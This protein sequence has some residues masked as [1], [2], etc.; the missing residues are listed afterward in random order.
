MTVIVRVEM[1]KYFEE[2]G[3][4][5]RVHFDFSIFRYFD[6]ISHSTLADLCEI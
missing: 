6:S 1:F 5:V 4:Y 2:G 3:V